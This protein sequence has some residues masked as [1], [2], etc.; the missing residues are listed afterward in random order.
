M[1]RKLVGAYQRVRTSRPSSSFD[2]EVCHDP[3][4]GGTEHVAH[5][6]LLAGPKGGRYSENYR[7]HVDCHDGPQGPA[8][9]HEAPPGASSGKKRAVTPDM[10]IVASVA[11]VA[12]LL[13]AGAVGAWNW[14]KRKKSPELT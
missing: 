9:G 11:V 13:A 10:V 6:Y 7:Y 5:E 3:I 12:L 2:C 1:A 14:L 4:P 8:G